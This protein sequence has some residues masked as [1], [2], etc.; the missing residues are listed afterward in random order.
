MMEQTMPQTASSMPEEVQLKMLHSVPGLH[1]AEIMDNREAL[2]L[3]GVTFAKFFT[4]GSI[5]DADLSAF[6]TE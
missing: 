6:S 5:S 1:R 4:D 3:S 2:T